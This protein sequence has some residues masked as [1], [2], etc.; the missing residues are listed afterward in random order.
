MLRLLASVIIIMVSRLDRENSEEAARARG[1]VASALVTRE[2][3]TA[4]VKDVFGLDSRLLASESERLGAVNAVGW[5]TEFLH[6]RSD[7]QTKLWLR[8][9]RPHEVEAHACTAASMTK[10]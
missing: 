3:L 5:I 8:Q 9:L 1:L 10:S 4:W 6:G 7:A 2:S